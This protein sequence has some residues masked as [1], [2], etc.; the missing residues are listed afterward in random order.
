MIVPPWWC[1]VGSG[2]NLRVPH[3][4]RSLQRVSY[5]IASVRFVISHRSQKREATVL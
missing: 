2:T 3:P 5:A 4:L 1:S